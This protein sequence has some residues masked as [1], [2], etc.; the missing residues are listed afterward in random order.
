MRKE[1]MN[2][3]VQPCQLTYALKCNRSLL[4]HTGV[5]L[6]LG[7]SKLRRSPALTMPPYSCAPI[8]VV[9]SV[10]PSRGASNR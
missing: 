3:P 7:H 10:P 6:S 8:F 2:W 1:A 4:R 5:N 9:I